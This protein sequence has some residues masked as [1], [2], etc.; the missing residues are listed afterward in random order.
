MIIAGLMLGMFLSALDQT[1]VATALPRISADLKGAAHLSWIVSAYLL[2]STAA[3]PI[4][5]KLSDLHGRKVMLQVAI[6]LFLATSLLCAMATSMG[7]LITFRA[8]QGLG[9]GGL[10]AMAH[11]TIADVISPRERGRYQ[12]YIAAVFAVASVLGPVLG[13]F[14]VDHLTWRW[15]FWI[16]LP[17]GLG[18]LVISQLTLRRLVAKRVRHRID[19]LG[20][21]LI[22][23]A[24]CCILLVTTMGGNEVPWNAPSIKALIGGA[25]LL[26]VAC[27]VQE[28]RSSEPVLPPRLFANRTFVI[29]NLINLLVSIG[30][31]G[32][33][34]FMPLF[35][36][37]V[38]SL[39]AGRSGVMLIPLTA[40][41]VIG[42]ITTGRLVAATGRYWIY[43]FLGAILIATG[44]VLLSLVSVATPL[45]LTAL[46][47][48]LGGFGIGLIMPVMMVVVQNA[49]DGRDLGTATSSISFFRSMGGSFGVAL[50]GAVLMARLNTLLAGVP[51]HEALG[52]EPGIQILH[53]GSQALSLVPLGAREAIGF[54]VAAAFHDVF[55]IGAGI[56][57]VTFLTVLLLKEVPLR[58][59]VD[60]ESGTNSSDGRCRAVGAGGLAD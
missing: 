7:Q 13:G 52:P 15:V 31:L 51:G 12:A 58:A 19:Y 44:M 20:A 48:A 55:R 16:N 41:S 4:Y 24:V 2:T 56:A 33:I 53:A 26:V 36:Q 5:G 37:L 47:M 45:Y 14:F 32:S 22:V 43:P 1:I 50:F 59:S 17:I 9:G 39:D 57:I 6:T 28:L 49:V 18:A 40:T 29:A 46:A 3:T 30:M 8:L 10:I 60:R 11:A 27:V 25:I 35:L 54:V 38:Y 42:A 34:V 23:S 21:V